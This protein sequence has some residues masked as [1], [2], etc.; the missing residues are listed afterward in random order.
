VSA[1]ANHTS[2]IPPETVLLVNDDVLVRLAVAAYLRD[3]GYRVVEAVNEEEALAI[4]TDPNVKVDVVFSDVVMSGAMDGFSLAQW[5]CENR[6]GVDV[7]LA[8]SV[9]R[10]ASAAAEVC[11]DGPLPRPYEPQML[12]DRIKRLRAARA[13]KR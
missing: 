13:A 3:C 2:Q 7:I 4:L 12:V 9:E 5:V 6:P 8:A 1:E 10:T 11:N